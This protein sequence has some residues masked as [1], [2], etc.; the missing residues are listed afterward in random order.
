MRELEDL[1][2]TTKNEIRSL[3][4][5][6][7]SL[8]VGRTL[9]FVAIFLSSLTVISD[10]IWGGE[11]LVIV[12]DFLLLFGCVASLLILRLKSRPTYFWIPL[13]ASFWLSCLPFFWATG[14]IAS[15]FIGI[16]L[17]ALYLIGTVLD[18]RTRSTFYFTL[19]LLHLPVFYF[20]GPLP[21]PPMSPLL[22]MVVNVL[23][24]AAIF[25]GLH[26]ILRTENELASEFT[27][28]FQDLART[29]QQLQLRESELV[30][31]K[32]ELEDRVKERTLALEHANKAKMQFLMNMSH[33]MRTPM[34]SILGFS[35]LLATENLSSQDSRDYLERIRNNGHR[36]MRLIE[37]ILDL[38][39]FE[40]GRIPIRKASFSLKKLVETVVNSFLPSLK[41]KEMVLELKFGGESDLL[42]EADSDRVGQVLTNLLSNSVKFS[43]KGKIQVIVNQ[44]FVDGG[45]RSVVDIVDTGIGI[46]SDDI[47]KLFQPFTQADS[48]VGRRF[49]GSGIGLAISRHIA[50]L[51]EGDLELVSSQ[52]GQGSHFRFHFFARHQ[53]QSNVKE[54]V[55][56]TKASSKKP[57]RGQKILIVDDSEDNAFLVR[58]YAA[59]LGF[60]AEI[61]KDG[62]EAIQAVK[63]SHFDCILMDIQMPGMDGWET[64]RSIRALGFQQPILAVSAHAFESDVEKSLAAGCNLHLAKPLS[65]LNLSRALEEQLG[66]KIQK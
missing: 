21:V 36:L 47:R 16:C 5:E 60:E 66:S 9:C 17:A 31:I 55:S 33:E 53:P 28:H 2:L 4:R 15:P 46:S 12:A 50:R 13:F 34:N 6:E 62:N 1:P 27:E 35:E 22:L 30:K 3:W 61:V 39:K 42:I 57:G 25:F 20:L 8:R 26:A 52:P 29:H 49:G 19:A 56:D 23:N 58:N 41:S 37:D 54:T 51:M 10:I 40:E 11:R 14:G 59:S 43:D 63:N 38:S 65:M 64:T 7:R 48:S 44:E 45:V 24:L 32:D 18:S